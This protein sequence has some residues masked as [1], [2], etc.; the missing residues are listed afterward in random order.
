[1]NF[2]PVLL[3]LPIPDG[4]PSSSIGT[5]NV[6]ISPQSTVDISTAFVSITYFNF[7]IPVQPRLVVPLSNLNYLSLAIL[8]LFGGEYRIRT[9]DP[10]LAKQVL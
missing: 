2:L 3:Q 10:L 6:I 7:S 5:N 8:S 1:M 9:D 4:Y